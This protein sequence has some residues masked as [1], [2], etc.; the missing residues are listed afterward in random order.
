MPIRLL[1]LLM[2]LSANFSIHA[3]AWAQKKHHY[4]TKATFIHADANRVF[5]NASPN[6]FNDYALYVYGE[7]G[8][9][10][11]LSVI[12]NSPL[13]KRSVS[14]ADFIR[15]TT[16][17][18][19]AGDVE[20]QA[21]YQFL[22]NP[23]AVSVFGGIKFPLAYEIADIPPLGNGETDLFGGLAIGASFYPVPA[24]VTGDIGYRQRGGDFVDELH[25]NIE[26]G[27]TLFQKW[28]VR[29]LFNNIN[30]TESA[31]GES[32]L[33]G[34]PLSQDKTRIGGGLIYLLTKRIELDLTYMK[35]TSGSNIPESTEFFVGF[36]FKR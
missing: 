3:G 15:G 28:L 23:L 6:L 22:A 9:F 27:Y 25:V 7:Y 14:E 5:G 32:T 8:L 19:V 4:Y 26:G 1:F 20:F 34:F 10:N 24:Y 12:L 18:L 21:K 35:T 2:L 33:F 29:A 11:N 36:A 30:S 13:Y 16:E 31:V 17:G